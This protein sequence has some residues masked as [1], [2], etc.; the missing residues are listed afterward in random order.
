MLEEDAVRQEFEQ[1]I[2]IPSLSDGLETFFFEAGFFFHI[3]SWPG[4]REITDACQ[5]K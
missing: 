1:L 5:G 2:F 4:L 3:L